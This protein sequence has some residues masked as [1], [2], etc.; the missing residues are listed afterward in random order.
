MWARIRITWQYF[1]MAEKS[2]SS[3][4]LPSSSCH[5]LQYLVKA[6]FLDLYLKPTRERLA[7]VLH[8]HQGPEEELSAEAARPSSLK[9]VGL[10]SWARLWLM[11]RFLNRSGEAFHRPE[12]PGAHQ[13][14]RR[15]LSGAAEDAATVRDT[16]LDLNSHTEF[17]RRRPAAH[18][19]L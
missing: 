18:Q 2:F 1:F 16:R 19:F 4:F 8:G 11:A 9:E 15:R 10:A 5:F 14:R 7:E 3:C 12:E 13:G 17:T 6:F